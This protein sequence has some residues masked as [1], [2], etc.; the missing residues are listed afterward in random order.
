MNLTRV[1]AGGAGSGS[2]LAR[3]SGR[4]GQHIL[5]HVGSSRSDLNAVGIG[6]LPSSKA[7]LRPTL[8]AGSYMVGLV[9][10]GL[11]QPGQP[12]NMPAN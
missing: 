6:P 9:R 3:K 12:A 4:R 7:S 5:T 1:G 2:A 11:F 10:I 8:V